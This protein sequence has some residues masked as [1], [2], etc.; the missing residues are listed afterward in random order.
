MPRLFVFLMI[1]AAGSAG[2][3][4]NLQI[5]KEL[6]RISSPDGV[7]DAV[8]ITIPTHATVATPLELHLVRKGG[9][10]SET[11]LALRGDH[12]NNVSLKWKDTKF[13]EV[14]YETLRIFTFQNFWSSKDVSNFSYVVEIRLKPTR[15]TFA[16]GR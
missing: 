14:Q 2:C 7:V 15:D 12:F 5:D 11:T 6:S 4:H 13:L 8:L 3:G 16:L 10:P 1:V 9:R